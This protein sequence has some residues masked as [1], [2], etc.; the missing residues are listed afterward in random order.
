[1][2]CRERYPM[3]N[4][5]YDA[6]WDGRLGFELAAEF[7]S[8]PSLLGLIF[9]DRHADESFSLYDHPQVSIF[10]KVRD[11][12]DAE[13]DALFS[14]IWEERRPRLPG[15]G[16][17]AQPL[18]QRAGVGQPAGQRTQRPHQPG[19]PSLLAGG[20]GAALPQARAERP[21]LTFDTA[22]GQQLPIVDNY[23]W[24]T[25]ASENTALAVAWWWLVLALLGWLVWP[26]AFVIFRPLRDAGYF[27]ARTF[28]WL[29]GGWLLWGLV[30]TGLLRNSVTHSSLRAVGGGAGRAGQPLCLPPPRRTGRFRTCATGRFCWP[31]E[32]CLRGGL[33]GLRGGAPAQPRPVAALVW[34]RETDG[35][36]VPQWH[37]AQPD[38]SAGESPHLPGASS[39]TITSGSIWLAI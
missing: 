8:P 9:D 33:S 4:L 22:N 17:A 34:R 6:M 5:Y 19:D 1:M 28:G 39:T 30:N 7:T 35:I 11:L 36:R 38:L 2:N 15:P 21:S 29:V 20:A 3:T 25:I 24:N 13:M 27:L 16:F 14:R 12:C 10:R 26:V 37:P 18:P 23:R 32:V 31:S